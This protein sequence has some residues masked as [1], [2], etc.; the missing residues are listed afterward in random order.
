MA[1]SKITGLTELAATPSSGDMLVIVDVSDTTMAATGT[2]KK[3][4]AERIAYLIAANTFTAL[5]TIVPTSTSTNGLTVNMPTANNQY[6]VGMYLNGNYRGGLYCRSGLSGMEVQSADLGNSVSG[7]LLFVGRNSN[8][9]VPAAGALQLM[10]RNGTPVYY[11]TD[12]TGALRISTSGAPTSAASDTSGVI[13]G[14]QTS[15]IGV[16]KNVKP[17]SN[18]NEA[19][20]AILAADLYSYQM[21]NDES[22]TE[23]YGL[24]ITEEDRENGAWFAENLAEN[25]IPTLNERSLFGYLI[26]AIKAQQTQIDELRSLLETQRDEP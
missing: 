6:A 18:P 24:V 12:A 13:V 14:T 4:N 17:W 16:K 8:A 26:A 23:Y 25:Q 15:W 2:D 9:T 10:A 19:L 7:P 3:F 20:T 5:Q 21:K 22:G 11:W 1:D